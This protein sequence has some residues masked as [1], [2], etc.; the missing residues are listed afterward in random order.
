MIKGVRIS[1]QIEL[2]HVL[3]VYYMLMFGEGT[4]G[5]LEKLVKVLDD[6]QK[7]TEMEINMEKLNYHIIMFKRTL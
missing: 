6:Y 4:Y 2:T 7:A 3:F 1:N 5:N